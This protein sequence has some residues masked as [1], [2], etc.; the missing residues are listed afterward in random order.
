MELVDLQQMLSPNLREG[1]DLVGRLW[2]ICSINPMLDRSRV[3]HIRRSHLWPHL[4]G[5]IVLYQLVQSTFSW[6]H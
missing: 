6:D 4:T 1:L 2:T 3:L 5:S